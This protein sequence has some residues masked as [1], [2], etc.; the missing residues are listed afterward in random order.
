MMMK[1]GKNNFR[2][3]PKVE[4]A[5][6]RIEPLNPAPPINY[7]EWDGLIRIC[8]NRK[9]KTLNACFKTKPVLDLLEKNYKVFLSRNNQM[10]D[11]NKIDIKEKVTQVLSTGPHIFGERRARTIGQE[12]YLQKKH[13]QIFNFLH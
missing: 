8:F 10:N 11:D 6:V 13:F 5:V 9:N 3:P 2:P 1:V 4:S 12:F 7:N